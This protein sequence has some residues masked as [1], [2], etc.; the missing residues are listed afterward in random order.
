[1]KLAIL[2][3]L[4]LFF[5]KSLSVEITRVRPLS[6]PS[7]GGTL[8]SVWGNGFI[9]G[10]DGTV[11]YWEGENVDFGKGSDIT[12]YVNDT[13]LQCTLP[14]LEAVENFLKISIG[15]SHVVVNFYLTHNQTLSTNH[16]KFTIFNLSTLHVTDLSPTEGLY[17]QSQDLTFSLLSLN[18]TQELACILLGHVYPITGFSL[19]S[20]DVVTCQIPPVSHSRKEEAC[21]S[22]NGDISGVVPTTIGS[23]LEFTFYYSE[24]Q[25]MVSYSPSL[26]RLYLQFDRE[27]EIGGREQ[28]NSTLSPDC[29]LLFTPDTLAQLGTEAVC[30]WDNYQQGRLVIELNNLSSLRNVSRIYYATGQ[31]IRTRYIVSSN[32]LQGSSPIVQDDTLPIPVLYAYSHIPT[33][34]SIEFDAGHSQLGGSQDLVAIWE[35]S[36]LDDQDITSLRAIFTA[37][38]QLRW[39]L[40]VN[41]FTS[42]TDYTID[43]SL[44]NFVG[45]SKTHSV[46]LTESPADLPTVTVHHTIPGTLY[47]NRDTLIL[48]SLEI[49]SCLSL[50]H[51]PL[52][53]SW[54]FSNPVTSLPNLNLPLLFIPG[55]TLT[56]VTDQ[57][58]SYTITDGTSSLTSQFSLSFS[59]TDPVALIL[60]G[61]TRTHYL[62]EDLVIDGSGSFDPSLHPIT[63]SWTCVDTENMIPCKDS[64]N[65]NLL[66]LASNNKYLL[67][68]TKLRESILKFSLVV[69]TSDSRT[70]VPYHLTVHINSSPDLVYFDPLPYPTYLV[71]QLIQ[72]TGWVRSSSA[73]NGLSISMKR[74]VTDNG[75]Y[76]DHSANLSVGDV[77][78][79]SFESPH[80]LPPDSTPLPTQKLSQFSFHL[81]ILYVTAG[82]RYRLLATLGSNGVATAATEID[83]EIDSGPYLGGVTHSSYTTDDGVKVYSMRASGWTDSPSALPLKYRYGIRQEGGV[84]WLTPS[85]TLPQLETP[86]LCS[87][88]G[89]VPLVLEVENML[90]SV[91]LHPYDLTITAHDDVEG[92]L[93][94]VEQKLV[95]GYNVMSGLSIMSSIIYFYETERQLIPPDT[96]ATLWGYLRSAHTSVLPRERSFSRHVIFLITEFILQ[97]STPSPILTE[98]MLDILEQSLTSVNSCPSLDM[99]YDRGISPQLFNNTVAAFAKLDTSNVPTWYRLPHL[100]SAL[101][102]ATRNRLNPDIVSH[103]HGHISLKVSHTS[104]SDSYYA[105]CNA[106]EEDC[107]GS[108][109]LVHFS[110]SAFDTYNSWGCVTADCVRESNRF[111]SVQ[112]SGVVIVT[113]KI[114]KHSYSLSGLYS[115]QVLSDIVSLY[116]L[117]PS[118]YEQ[119]TTTAVSVTLQTGTLPSSHACA[120]WSTSSLTW[121]TSLCT[122]FQIDSSVVRCECQSAGTIAVVTTCPPGSY[123]PQCSDTCPHGLW[124][125][126]CSQSC[127]CSHNST[128]LPTDGFCDCHPGYTG[129]KC[130]TECGNW[131]YGKYCVDTCGCYRPNSISCSHVDGACDCKPGF[132]GDDCA[133]TCYSG[134]WGYLCAGECSCKSTGVCDYVDGNCICGAGY[135]GVDCGLSCSEWSYGYDCVNNCT[136]DR[137]HTDTCVPT[138]GVCLCNSS[139]TGANCSTIMI[140]ITDDG[141]DPIIIAV[142]VIVVVVIAVLVLLIILIVICCKKRNKKMVTV[143]PDKTPI[144]YYKPGWSSPKDRLSPVSK[145]VEYEDFISTKVDSLVRVG[146]GREG[147]D[148]VLEEEDYWYFIEIVIID[149]KD[150]WRPHSQRSA[151]HAST[152][153]FQAPERPEIN[154]LSLSGRYSEESKCDTVF[155]K[156]PE[157]VILPRADNTLVDLRDVFVDSGL[158]TGGPFQFL[159]KN[160]AYTFIPLINEDDIELSTLEET[161]VYIQQVRDED[162]AMLELCVCGKVSQFECGQC[163]VRGYCGEDCQGKDWEEHLPK[164]LK[165]QNGEND[166]NMSLN[167]TMT[168]S[169]DNYFPEDSSAPTDLKVNQSSRLE[170]I[171]EGEEYPATTNVLPYIRKV[172]S[173]PDIEE[174][175]VTKSEA[176]LIDQNPDTDEVVLF[177][178]YEGRRRRLPA[179]ETGNK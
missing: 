167:V 179:D 50:T 63:Y 58:I 96:T 38:S 85:T 44:S 83:I 135:T 132:R 26:T 42:G 46:S 159:K 150:G 176:E 165:A 155:E 79:V 138:S 161:E 70:S 137:L 29:S 98:E 4:C 128:C 94:K 148:S 66:P 118:V 99:L 41:F 28:F 131:T 171:G 141:V 114:H 1:M 81:P 86:L 19:G 139:Y 153:P 119:L 163:G 170:K 152:T 37:Q 35:V 108:L 121:D 136:C 57:L 69:T 21:L 146:A 23:C 49:P 17:T 101:A 154:M 60:G 40:P 53:F 10:D 84:H 20:V 92:A 73:S 16:Y 3:V 130:D 62:G 71:N 168:T 97:T 164:C 32:V 149:E 65:N 125:A 112:C 169:I 72:V 174:R 76:F 106:R 36:S 64:N 33:C 14:D 82:Q 39:S 124:G 166:A 107:T 172:P 120:I 56:T 75:Y 162:I 102:A 67:T 9:G 103:S 68:H 7:H 147:S 24:P 47:T 55:Y 175:L 25:V 52:S 2:L 178:P 93:E 31:S 54:T 129:V 123:G 95:F 12:A 30:S 109:P 61:D 43:L 158:W 151:S 122:T 45:N 90:G 91:M 116:L 22:L 143:S 126:G 160:V 157:P 104:L 177:D 48:V 134:T 8:L 115:T 27:V 51:T 140:I 88:S 156:F 5:T 100:L 80:Q 18:Y 111:E 15:S 87:L 77:S 78:F 6:G 117:H 113:S 105:A 145:Q 173:V 11:C 74:G 144:Y 13:F 142:V 34:G 110:Q 127:I 133:T 89:V 59:L